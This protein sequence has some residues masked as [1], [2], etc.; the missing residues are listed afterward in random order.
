ME[1]TIKKFICGFVG[2]FTI[3]GSGVSLKAEEIKTEQNLVEQ[4]K[5]VEISPEEMLRNL[6]SDM[7]KINIDLND[8]EISIRHDLEIQLSEA[9]YCVHVAEKEYEQAPWYKR[10]SASKKLEKEKQ[11]ELKVS[12]DIKENEAAIVELKNR[13][14]D[15]TIDYNRICRFNKQ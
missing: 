12:S 5:P 7:E 2:V 4:D 8:R 11:N 10:I 6:I 14:K 9:V 13:Y 3:L 1:K 15:L